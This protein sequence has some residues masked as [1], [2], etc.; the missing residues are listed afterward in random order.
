MV[1]SNEVDKITFLLDSSRSTKGRIN[2]FPIE[3][4]DIKYSNSSKILNEK[5]V[6]YPSIIS[7]I[8]TLLSIYVSKITHAL[9]IETRFYYLK[10]KLIKNENSIKNI[11]KLIDLKQKEVNKANIKK[12]TEELIFMTQLA[13]RGTKND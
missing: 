4:L 12:N 5:Q 11:D 7:C 10:E 6:F 9:I 8:D 13:K 3:E 2:I 1:L